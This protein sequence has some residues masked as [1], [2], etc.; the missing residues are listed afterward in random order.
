MEKRL[1]RA[2]VVKTARKLKALS[3]PERFRI[4]LEL[5]KRECCVGELQKC[6]SLSQPHVSQ[7]LRILKQAKIV[8]SRRRERRI[9]YRVTDPQTME[10]VKLIFE[11]GKGKRR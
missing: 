8:S 5:M 11:P 1:P 7:S 9:C 10:L 4:V 3:H 6:V 2:K